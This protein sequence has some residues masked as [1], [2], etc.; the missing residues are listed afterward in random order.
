MMQRHSGLRASPTHI[1]LL[2][3][4]MLL[5][6]LGLDSG[7]I[8]FSRNGKPHT[9]DCMM[10]SP[11][12]SRTTDPRWLFHRR[13]WPDAIDDVKRRMYCMACRQRRRERIRP[14]VDKTKK[15]PTGA[16]LLLPSDY[17]WRKLIVR[18]RS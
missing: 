15:A 10:R 9:I 2:R 18:Y 12:T 5:T 3:S 13:R 7:F 4:A 8:V 14:M 17:D 11:A 16:P 6:G 1:P